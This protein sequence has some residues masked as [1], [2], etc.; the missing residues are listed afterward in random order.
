[1]PCSTGSLPALP[2][3][4]VVHRDEPRQAEWRRRTASE[5]EGGLEV[6][7]REVLGVEGGKFEAVH[8]GGGRDQIIDQSD[9]GM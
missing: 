2:Q 6:E 9:N 7:H 5:R 1:M 3:R 4:R 8:L